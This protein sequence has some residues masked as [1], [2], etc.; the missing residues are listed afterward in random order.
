METVVNH[1]VYYVEE[2]FQ[3]FNFA[4]V[5][6]AGLI[7]LVAAIEEFASIDAEGVTLKD[8]KPIPW[9]E[10]GFLHY[11]GDLFTLTYLEDKRVLQ[12]TFSEADC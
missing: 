2:L 8:G 5:N 1:T 9:A 7:R 12:I 6:L 11:G 3:I 4:Q 10:H